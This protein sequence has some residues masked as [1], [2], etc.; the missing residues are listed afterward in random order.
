MNESQKNSVLIKI[1]E[2]DNLNLV[3]ILKENP[4]VG[5]M[6]SEKFINFSHLSVSVAVFEIALAKA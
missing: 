1:E 3:E 6:D 2:F 4:L 5:N